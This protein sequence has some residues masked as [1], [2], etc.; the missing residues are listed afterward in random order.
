MIP[1]IKK[2]LL[3]LGGLEFIQQELMKAGG[4][5]SAA[6]L[7]EMDREELEAEA[8]EFNYGA[9][10]GL[11]GG[12]LEWHVWWLDKV[13]EVRFEDKASGADQW[14]RGKVVSL[15]IETFLSI[16]PSDK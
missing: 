8:A 15:D 14:C 13:V 4:E 16:L 5:K 11:D 6:I 2:A 1:G 9:S 12:D 3:T 10:R 7:R